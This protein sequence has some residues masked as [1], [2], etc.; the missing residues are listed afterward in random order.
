MK[1]LITALLAWFPLIFTTLAL[2]PLSF[3]IP[4]HAA[5]PP[6]AS[7]APAVSALPPDQARAVLEMLN[8]P[9]KRA[10]FTATLEAIVRAT[11]S[12]RPVPDETELLSTH[13]LGA[14]ILDSASNLAGRA[15]TRVTEIAESLN[16][17]P[18]L[19]G[20]LSVMATNPI[21]HAILIDSAGRLM[22]ALL[23]ASAALF[24]LDRFIRGPI[25]R[26]EA[27]IGA[28]PGPTESL[29]PPEAPGPPLLDGNEDGLARAE[30]GDV[31]SIPPCPSAPPSPRD[32]TL[33][34]LRRAPPI[35]ARMG[36]EA[37]PVLGFML[38][39]HLV[40]GSNLG[41]QAA[42]RLIIITVA[43]AMGLAVLLARW[44]H[45]L[46]SWDSLASPKR[47]IRALLTMWIFVYA[48][49]E[50]G[51]LLGMS[52]SAHDMLLKTAGLVLVIAAGTAALRYRAPIGCWLAPAGAENGNGDGG[53]ARLRAA[54]AG[55]WHRITLFILVTGWLLW[56]FD[57][58]HGVTSLVRYAIL[59]AGLIVL[60]RLAPSLLADPATRLWHRGERLAR[61]YPWAAG[62][63]TVYRP[64][65]RAVTRIAIWLLAITLVLSLYGLQ[66]IDW[67]TSSTTGVRLS[68]G[69]L[70]LVVTL[71]LAF[72]IWEAVNAAIGH[73]LDRLRR[74]AR[75][76]QS[77]RLRTLLPLLRTA[78]FIAISVV[79]VMMVLS[80][81][82]VNIAPLLAGA[83]IVGVAIGFGSQ[84]LVHDLI[85]GIFLLLENA[86]QVG[87]A[88]TV[89][90]LSGTVEALSVRTIRLR[91]ADGSV[92]IIPFSAVTSV[93]NVHR[94]QGNAAV[95]VVIKY[96]EDLDRTIEVLKEIAAGM[97]DDPAFS[98]RMLG[99][100]QVFG[101]DKVDGASVTILG[102]IACTD[103]G[104]WPVQR[105]FNRR[106]VHRF[107]EL[108][109]HLFNPLGG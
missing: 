86:M 21:A 34:V 78:L 22:I 49:G 8:D 104:R 35:L 58:P 56:A 109:V 77:A 68:S 37:V 72:G 84:T 51:M 15:G 23:C 95:N 14:R 70:S 83:G 9:A 45:L 79:T 63:A 59:P 42:S 99:D 48:F 94:G 29:P 74:E 87:D 57:V 36:L 39:G 30:A 62:R 2:N 55:S 50:A 28:R 10:A 27:R 19:L 76:A 69:V 25:R 101:V 44:L 106:M 81:I 3:A 13:G 11:P 108:E 60:A 75:A 91:A 47:W 98:T 96:T 107:R 88:V 38:A 61:R 33:A 53:V 17:L 67:L 46:P 43:D 66:P 31:E 54:L 64:T 97:R 4:V 12:Q 102:Q 103:T 32:N 18:L 24:A 20:W 5:T 26:L 41:G 100:L 16:S 52:R 40:A 92:H 80:E 6:S 1:R 71:L 93:T 73:H 85:T 89:S 65:V 7:S 105:E 82:G 90:G